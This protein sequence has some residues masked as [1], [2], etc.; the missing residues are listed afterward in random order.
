MSLQPR[1]YAPIEQALKR[2][3]YAAARE[4][5]QELLRIRAD[6][7]EALRLL[8]AALNGMG[9]GDEA[10]AA[11]RRAVDLRPDDPRTH[12]SLG[13]AL[14]AIGDRAGANAAFAR[15]TTVQPDFAPGWFNLATGL[16]MQ[17]DNAA[18]LH[19]I[20][21]ILRLEPMS[22]RAKIMR[23]DVWRNTRP[24]N[25]VAAEYRRLIAEFPNSGW[26]WF[27]YSN[28]K[29][30]P[31]TD[32]DVACMQTLLPKIADER[33]R[34][35]LTFALAKAMEDAGR[36]AE[37]FAALSQANATA[38]KFIPW[39]A[40]AFSRAIDE[41]MQA[42]PAPN[43]APDGRGRAAIFIV[44]LPRSGTTLIEQILCS[45][46]QVAGGGEMDYLAQA[47]AGENRR[48]GTSIAQWAATTNATDWERLGLEYLDNGAMR[49]G[50]AM[51]LTDKTPENWI[52]AGAALAMLP[53]ARIVNCRR[54]PV[55]A[56]FS[57][58]KQQF[59]ATNQAFSYAI[60]DIAAYWR[61]YDRAGRHWREAFPERFLDFRY[62][63]VQEDLEGAVRK[64]LQFCGLEFE[65]ACLRFH[66]NR[67]SVNTVSAAQVREPI[68]RDTARAHKYGA[69]LDPLRSELGM[70][71]WRSEDGDGAQ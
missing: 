48:R 58:Y 31:F 22:L 65:P 24:G 15:A 6:D 60:P 69:L 56:G 52:Y 55:E 36:Y 28:L 12:N 5:A 44:G 40:V 46:S 14:H 51:Y 21:N 7:A 33:E 20:E 50:Q 17:E 64:L 30:V 1:I 25:E 32:A 68:R 47:I 35:S 16:M 23:S 8:G 2:R 57:C 27:G 18:T 38:R 43:S 26:P 49:R 53:Q 41:I 39:D 19:A 13:A 9:R 34:T 67:R 42:F 45:H 71:L 61:D 3:A 4:L 70:P 66:E 11:I 37:A 63:D 29:S 10:I 59:S 62:E 54:D